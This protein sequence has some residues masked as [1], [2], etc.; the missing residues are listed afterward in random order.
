MHHPFT[1]P[2]DEDMHLLEKE[3]AR[4]RARHYDVVC[5]GCEISSGSIRIHNRQ[6]QE[7]IF[8]L[9]GYSD[10]EAERRFG[11]LLGAFDYGAPPHGGIA[12]GIDRLVML[13]AGEKTIREVIA[14]PKN[15]TAVDVMSDAPSSV[16]KQQLDELHLIVKDDDSRSSSI[17]QQ[18]QLKY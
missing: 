13:L 9:L 18:S 10:E 11:Q 17:R 14:F 3:P 2:L 7:K 16:S 1:A 12:P 15:Q 6:M 4:V 5:N 8:K